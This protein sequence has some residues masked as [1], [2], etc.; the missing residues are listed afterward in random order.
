M[1]RAAMMAVI[2]KDTEAK[3][4]NYENG[5]ISSW[6]PQQTILSHSATGWFLSHCGQNSTVEAVVLGVPLICWPFFADQPLNSTNLTVNHHVAYELFE[7]RTGH[8]L[9]PVHRLG[10]SPEGT[11]YAIREEASAILEKAFGENGKQKRAN[12]K[13]L[14][15][16][17][18][19]ARLKD[20]TSNQDL[21]ALVESFSVPP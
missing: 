6:C 2:S 4:S 13:I 12:M 11:T 9:R 10:R 14:Q 16:Q 19:G 15:K 20:A 17:V 1:S 5:I 18:L 21:R 8:G 7:V 3:I